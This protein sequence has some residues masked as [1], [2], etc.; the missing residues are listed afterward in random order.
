VGQQRVSVAAV[1]FVLSMSIVVFV[2]VGS[3]GSRRGEVTVSGEAPVPNKF[4]P[5]DPEREA[6]PWLRDFAGLASKDRTCIAGNGR[7]QWPMRGRDN[8]SQRRLLDFKY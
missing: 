5:A 6:R 8:R 4:L 2:L 1:G 7:S 3:E